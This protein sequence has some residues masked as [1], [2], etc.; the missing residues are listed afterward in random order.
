MA[1]AVAG[2]AGARF[3]AALILVSALGFLSVIIMT[4][5]RLYFAM[6]QE[7]LLPRRA[8]ALH[9]RFR[10]PTFTLWL[11]AA[12]SIALL[13]TN[14]YDQLL[15]YVV[16]AD[17]LFFGLTVGGLFILRRREPRPARVLSMP[18][19]PVTTFAFVATAAGIVVN[20]FFAYTTQS[21]IGTAI[22]LLAAAS[23]P[24]VAARRAS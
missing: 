5:P 23:Y 9:P 18:G 15:S 2:D 10:T 8:A 12:I 6:A 13:L 4:A 20:S 22:L 17:W 21:L 16:F 7:G 19:H 24:L 11:Q 14:R 1:R 3:V